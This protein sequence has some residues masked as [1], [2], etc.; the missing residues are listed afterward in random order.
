MMALMTN[1]FD[2]ANAPTTEPVSIIA[3]DFVQW[4]RSD[5][6]EYS[7]ALYTLSYDCRAEGTPS[8][9]VTITAANDGDGYIVTLSSATTAAYTPAN[10][11]YA[12]I[13]TRNSDGARITLDTGIFTVSANKATSADDPRTFALKMLANIESALLHRATNNQL[14]VLAYS[15]GAETSATRDPAKLLMHREY[16]QKE[17]VKQNRKIRARKGQKHSGTIGVRF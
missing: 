11:H 2:T 8:V 7:S 12:I 4:K 3:G 13:I 6:G 5:L 17:L 15:L 16:W 1:L 14:D 10:Y 9:K